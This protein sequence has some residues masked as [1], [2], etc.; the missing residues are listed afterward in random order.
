[1]RHTIFNRLLYIGIFLGVIIYAFVTGERVLF[2][3]AVVLTA[4]PIIS[5]VIT[6]IMLR[7]LGVK[8]ATPPTVL[9][10][11]NATFKIRLHNYT[12]FPIANIEMVFFGQEHAIEIPKI[13]SFT[14]NPFRHMVLEIPFR[15]VY[16]G[17]YQLGLSAIKVTDVSGLFKL[18]R[19]YNKCS[20]VL[21]LPHVAEFNRF[22]LAMNLMSQ[23]H[24]RFDIRDEDYATISDI[25][26]YIPTDSIKRVHW[27]LTAKRNEWLVKI[28]QSN[29]LNQV[30]II[31]DSQRAT[32]EPRERLALEDS[33]IE[34]S[35]SLAN[36]CLNKGMP[37]DFY[38]TEGHETKAKAPQAFDEIYHAA[39]VINFT[40][41]TKLNTTAILSHVLNEA[42][43]YVNA[44]IF[45]PRLD[46]E[47]CE[48]ILNAIN[49][50]H[51]IAVIYFATSSDAESDS[52][53]SLLHAGNAPCFCVS[54]HN[55]EVGA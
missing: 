25:R 21:A 38:V 2:V 9:K 46:K 15:A 16:R 17:Q 8:Q 44:V 14:L 31:I 4:L 40:T 35:I 54:N 28:F 55:S 41:E 34:M 51:Y 36:F 45:T 13:R 6:F 30:S 43:G 24:S 7:G 48:R 32:L 10:H 12:P 37:T 42:T 18:K 27:K 23:A 5:Y 53:Y 39:S 29:A 20:T 50:G 33:M 3:S 19:I 26:A 22:P 47:L 49:N 52:V 1:M 11:E